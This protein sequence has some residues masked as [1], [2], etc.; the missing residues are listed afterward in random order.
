M[1]LCDCVVVGAVIEHLSGAVS[2][3][4]FVFKPAHAS[5][6]RE[7]S[8]LWVLLEHVAKLVL[9]QLRSFPVPVTMHETYRVLINTKKKDF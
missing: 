4:A 3:G 1:Y 6:E 7:P 9:S 8:C 2:A 5:D